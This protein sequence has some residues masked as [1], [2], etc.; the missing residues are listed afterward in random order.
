MAVVVNAVDAASEAS[1]AVR[2]VATGDTDVLLPCEFVRDAA[3]FGVVLM[4][5]PLVRYPAAGVA[6]AA[7][8]SLRSVLALRTWQD[9]FL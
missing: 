6:N 9:G 3:A 2:A 4:R 1:V 7:L 5:I 8:S